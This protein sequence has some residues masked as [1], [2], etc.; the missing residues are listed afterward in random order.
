MYNELVYRILLL[1]GFIRMG[2][3]NS[4]VILGNV[5]IAMDSLQ[6][7]TVHSSHSQFTARHQREPHDYDFSSPSSTIEASVQSAANAQIIF[8]ANEP[9][10][11]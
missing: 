8:A 11:P 6:Y 4:V 7:F 5:R 1:D 3:P 2:S 9:P 10:S